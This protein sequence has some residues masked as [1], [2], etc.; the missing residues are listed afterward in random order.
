MCVCVHVHVCCILYGRVLLQNCLD[1]KELYCSACFTRFHHKG[2]LRSHVS[3]TIM[4][5]GRK[6]VELEFQSFLAEL[7]Y[8]GGGGEGLIV[9]NTSLKISIVHCISMVFTGCLFGGEEKRL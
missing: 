8:L 4:V 5:Y 1:C 7:P 9:W 2:A 6:E 3:E